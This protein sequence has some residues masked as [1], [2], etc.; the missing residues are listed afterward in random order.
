MHRTFNGPP[1][2]VRQSSTTL[3]LMF[4]V[5]LTLTLGLILTVT[6]PN[7]ALVVS[8]SDLGT[9]IT[10]ILLYAALFASTSF[11]AVT[12]FSL[13]NPARLILEPRG[14]TCKRLLGTRHLTWDDIEHF[15]VGN[16]SAHSSRKVVFYNLSQR[17]LWEHPHQQSPLRHCGTGWEKGARELADLL[18]S[19]KARWG[20]D[21][22]PRLPDEH[23]DQTEPV[24]KVA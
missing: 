23:P 13:I 12:A 8:R 18:N 7:D 2:I 15:D 11:A 9:T 16:I 1:I 21:R 20:E 10:G 14:M 22:T 4:G 5:W 6:H 17:Y 24:R 3:I 19:A